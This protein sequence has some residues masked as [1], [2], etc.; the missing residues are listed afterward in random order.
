MRQQVE[1]GGEEEDEA[2]GRA[3]DRAGTEAEVEREELERPDEEGRGQQCAEP[4]IARAKSGVG[5]QPVERPEE[6]EGEDVTDETRRQLH[7]EVAYLHVDPDA[8]GDLAAEPGRHAGDQHRRHQHCGEGE[9]QQQSDAAQAQAP[10][11]RDAIM[12]EEGVPDRFEQGGAEPAEDREA[13]EA[14]RARV[15]PD[16]GEIFELALPGGREEA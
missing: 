1:P 2:D 11:A 12:L 15:L 6:D 8:I 7:R 5:D 13:D 4:G 16:G 14:E 3:A 10:L 9:D